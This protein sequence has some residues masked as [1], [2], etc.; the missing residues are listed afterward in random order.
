KAF[1]ETQ[2]KAKSRETEKEHVEG[3]AS[4]NVR[5]VPGA[6]GDQGKGDAGIETRSGEAGPARGP[7]RTQ[8]ELGQGPEIQRQAVQ[9]LCG[10]WPA[11]DRRREVRKGGRKAA[12]TDPQSGGPHRPCRLRNI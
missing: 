2:E 8:A 3:S 7:Y 6:A 1:G 5:N 10:Q 11:L 12:G 4:A 9:A